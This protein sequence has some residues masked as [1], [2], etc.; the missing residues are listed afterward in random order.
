MWLAFVPRR[1]VSVPGQVDTQTKDLLSKRPRGPVHLHLPVAKGLYQIT[2]VCS[3]VLALFLTALTLQFQ[4]IYPVGT[5]DQDGNA[6][7]HYG[8]FQAP[9]ANVRPRFRYWLPDASV[10]QSQVA[11]DIRDAGKVG[12]GGIELLGYYLYGN[13]QI[14]PGNYDLLQSDWTVNYFGSP[15]W[16]NLQTVV[17]QTAQ[18]EGLL[19]DLALGPNQGAGVPAPSESDGLLW[20]LFFFEVSIPIGGIFDGVLPGWNSGALVAASTGLVLDA[21]ASTITLSH[22]SL[23]DITKSVDGNGHVKINFPSNK[24]GIENRLF[25]YYLKHSHYPE[26][27]AQDSV[28]TAVP[29]SPIKIYEQN[30]SWVVDHFSALGAQTIIDYW[31]NHLLDSSTINLIK[32]VGNYVWEDSQEFFFLENT[33]WTPKIQDTFSANRGYSVNKY[34][35]LLINRLASSAYSALYVTDESD[36]GLSHVADYRQT[37]TELNAVYLQTLTNWAEQT[38][39]IQF[40]AQVVYNLPM[41]MLANIPYVHAPE[42]ETLA[43]DS[44]IDGYKQFAGP[45]NLAGKRI[46]SSE[47]GASFGQTYQQTIPDLLSGFKRSIAGGVNNFIVHGYPYTGNYGNTTWPGFTA[48]DY[49]FSEMHGRHLPGWDFYSDWLDWL[50]RNQWVA[51]TGVPKV[52]LVFWTKS[53]NHKQ[54]LPKYRSNDLLAAGYSYEYLSPDNFALPEAYVL[55]GALAPRRQQFKA[56]VIRAN[57]ILTGLGLIKLSEYAIAGLPIIFH[58]GLPSKFHGYNQDGHA[59]ANSTISH[60][61][62]LRNVHVT[63]SGVGLAHTLAKIK[64]T[65]R[66]AVSGNG[67][68]YTTWRS[69]SSTDYVYVFN[70]DQ[71]FSSGSISF[72]TT[73]VPYT[74]NA[75]TGEITPVLVYEQSSTHTTIPLQLAGSQTTIIA[76]KN[77]GGESKRLYVQTD[78]IPAPILDIRSGSSS[79]ALSILLTSTSTSPIKLQLSTG[80]STTLSPVQRLIPA[81]HLSNWNLTIESWTSPSDPYDLNPVAARSNLTTINN[82]QTLLPWNELSSSLK[83]ISGRGYYSTSF[84]WPPTHHRNTAQ[85]VIFNRPPPTNNLGGA[86]LDLGKIFHTARVSVNGHVLPA[87][88]VVWARAD[89]SS[90]LQIGVNSVEVVVSTPLGNALSAIW[91]DVETSGKFAQSQIGAPWIAAYGLVDRVTVI[92]YEIVSVTG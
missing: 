55:D 50:S 63:S 31:Q 89:I 45:A 72:E 46:I 41:D 53:T 16:K 40:S 51:Q 28:L 36:S 84:V 1:F 86:L 11:D 14:F 32:K 60:L 78:S 37:L 43:F 5:N 39:G 38:L 33:F 88:D 26:V 22:T 87:L 80:K 42:C 76:F 77:S 20:D 2:T 12:S 68:W 71:S 3:I 47:S 29:Q 59:S 13:V 30:G 58:G 52:D 54:I 27:Q 49:T 67:T 23:N 65:P 8:T 82:I 75:W 44:N 6:N 48:F 81:F 24:P 10:N 4:L 85:K 69:D 61:I 21:T 74:Y 35:P 17:L 66:T 15:A 73:G 19:V 79:N 90:Y 92:P 91:G 62:S 83:T 7:V 25:A 70:V 9:S 56:I 64:V 57:E 18:E 34:I